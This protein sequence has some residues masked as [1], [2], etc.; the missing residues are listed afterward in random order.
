MTV[1]TGFKAWA[2]NKTEFIELWRI[3]EAPNDV[4]YVKGTARSAIRLHY[5]SFLDG[6]LT[7]ISKE[8]WDK[9]YDNIWAN[10]KGVIPGTNKQLL[11]ILLMWTFVS[12]QNPTTRI[13]RPATF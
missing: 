2:W 12:Q 4:T 5:G 11:G 10:A 9:L 7:V 3:G 6:C 13:A 8:G 1:R